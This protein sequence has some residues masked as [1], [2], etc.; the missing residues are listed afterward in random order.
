MNVTIVHTLEALQE[1]ALVI[2]ISGNGVQAAALQS[3]AAAIGVSVTIL[4][5]D[6]KGEVGEIH[7][8]YF[9]QRRIYLLGLGPKPAFAEVQ[10]AFRT[11]AYKLRQKLSPRIG[12][13]FLH[14][15]LHGETAIWVEAAVNGLLLGSYQLGRF[16]TNTPERHPFE[17]AEAALQIGIAESQSAAAAHAAHRAAIMADTQMRIL[18]LVNAPANKKTPTDLANWAIASGKK[19]SYRVDAWSQAEITAKGLHALLAVSQGSDE[20]PAFII[21]E[22][23]PEG[24]P[25][26][27]IGLVGKGVTFDTGGLSIKPSANMHLMKSDMGGAAAVFG[28]MEVIARTRPPFHV[29]GIVPATENTVDARSV[30]PSD[31]IG[32]YSGKTIEIIDTD[33]EGRLILADGLSYM[34]RHFQPDVLINLATLTGST[35]RALGYQAAGLFC[36]NDRLAEQLS[37]TGEH[38][39]ERMWRFPIWDAYKDDIKSD[40]ADVR[41][42]SGKPVAGGISAAKFLEVFIDEHTTWA[43]LDIAGVAFT[44]SEFS[45][46]KSATGYGVRLLTDFLETLKAEQEATN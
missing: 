44:D 26:Q 20:P 45:A 9:Q 36:N 34:V 43:H 42:L 12:V 32:S 1:E 19:Y 22:Y 18:D 3:V 24:K 35:V 11:F 29:I 28:A 4:Q 17:H 6:F 38:T 41:N 15:N 10:K 31:V 16:K 25:L 8:I 27:K 7:T 13:S 2:P 33:A 5:Q 21:M 23:V 40:V 39:G 46:Q 14:E 37:R 30:K